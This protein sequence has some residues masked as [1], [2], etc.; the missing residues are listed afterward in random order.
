MDIFESIFVVKSLAFQEITWILLDF[1][2]LT[3]YQYINC[4]H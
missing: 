4:N 1:M 3:T 2:S